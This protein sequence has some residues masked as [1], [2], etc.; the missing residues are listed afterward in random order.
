MGSCKILGKAPAGYV[1]CGEDRKRFD[2]LRLLNSGELLRTR[3]MTL[4]FFRDFEYVVRVAC[5]CGLL[6][7]HF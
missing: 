5:L 2:F 4:A 6:K 1:D 3:F 7:V